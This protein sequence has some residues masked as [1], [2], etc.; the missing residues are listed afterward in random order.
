MCRRKLPPVVKAPLHIRHLKDFSP[1]CVRTCALSTPAETK[2]LPHWEHLKGFSPVCDLERINILINEQ[3]SDTLIIFIIQN[4]PSYIISLHHH[5]LKLCGKDAALP[6]FPGRTPG[7][8]GFT[9]PA[10]SPRA[11]TPLRQ[12]AQ[13]PWVPHSAHGTLLSLGVKVLLSLFAVLS[14]KN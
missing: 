4:A 2:P 9:C 8:P 6:V 11:S 5:F 12:E 13:L 7:T 3:A 14:T 1:V 10:W